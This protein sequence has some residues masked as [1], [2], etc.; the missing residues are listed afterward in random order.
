MR[1]KNELATIHKFPSHQVDPREKEQKQWCLGW[2]KAAW[3]DYGRNIYDSFYHKRHRYELIESY[4]LG[5]Q[6]VSNY[7]NQMDIDESADSTYLNI[8]WNPIGI[9]T[10][11]RMMAVAR[12]NKSGFNITATP[13]DALSMKHIDEYFKKEEAKIKL[14]QEIQKIN[15]QLVDISPIAKGPDDPEDLEELAIHRKYKYKHFLAAKLEQSLDT[16]MLHNDYDEIRNRV[17]ERILDFG[18]GGV[19]EYIDTNGS[20]KIREVDPSRLI[21]SY[22]KKRDFSDAR[23]IGEV[24]EMSF[25]DLKQEAGDQISSG[26]Y[27][28]IAEEAIGSSIP[29]LRNRVSGSWD[30]M[31]DNY[32]LDVLDIE[33]MTVD[34]YIY[35]K[36]QDRRGNY[37]TSK[38]DYKKDGD[39]YRRL[40]AKVLY[41]CKW[42]VGTDI[43]YDYGRCTD[44]KRSRSMLQDTSYSYHLYAPTMQRMRIVGLTEQMIPI[45]DQ[46]HLAYYK[47]QQVVAEARPK[48]IAIEISGLLDTIGAL[49]TKAGKA[50]TIDDIIDLFNKR[51]ILLYSKLDADGRPSNYR[52]IEELN[53]GIGEE[54]MRWFNLMQAHMQ[55][56]RDTMGLNELTDGSTPDPRILTQIASMANENTN[57]ALFSYY[58]ADKEIFKSLCKSLTLRLQTLARTGRAKIY[59]SALGENTFRLLE[60]S[61]DLSNHEFG[62]RIE[63]K[64]DENERQMLIQEL[65]QF[66]ASGLVEYEDVML[67]RNTD[68]LKM[69]EAILAHR[70]SK[71]KREQKEEAMRNQQMNTQSQIQSAQAAEQAKQ[72]TLQMEH[73]MK[74]QQIEVEKRWDYMIEQLR[75]TGKSDNEILRNITQAEIAAAKTESE[76]YQTEILARAR[77]ERMM[78]KMDDNRK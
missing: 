25:A 40:S 14:R 63:N 56:M 33:W 4:A 66:Q 75:M 2:A 59:E 19:K 10:K 23:Y 49:D 51:G 46:F 73:Q 7:K 3:S 42:I 34:D 58:E 24:K 17:K 57:N 21:I 15:P 26:E 64:P 11:M 76:E 22:C 43:I 29:H 67:V 47:L 44:M 69:A 32:K 36:G 41:K 61:K 77:D 39:N 62:I 35:E 65:M 53:N 45:I 55:T 71:R 16:V 20:I 52:P 38:A 68:N 37:H 28:Y 78:T 60:L 13:I 1:K 50:M 12:I 5:Q 8:A 70:I 18:I 48:G 27:D 9:Y 74:L 6:S 72:Q 31:V 54:A 30:E